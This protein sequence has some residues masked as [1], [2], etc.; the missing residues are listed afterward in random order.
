MY[1]TAVYGSFPPSPV[2][3][4]GSLILFDP[5]KGERAAVTCMHCVPNL[6]FLYPNNC[7]LLLRIIVRDY[8][9]LVQSLLVTGTPLCSRLECQNVGRITYQITE[10]LLVS[11]LKIL[12]G[13][14]EVEYEDRKHEDKENGLAANETTTWRANTSISWHG[15]RPTSTRLVL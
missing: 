13:A 7:L 14:T 6:F 3:A 1:D 4:G 8:A 15:N 10:L 2:P 12:T 5:S 9:R 11:C